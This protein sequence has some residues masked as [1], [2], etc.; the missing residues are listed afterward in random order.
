MASMEVSDARADSN[1]VVRE[2]VGWKDQDRRMLRRDVLF[3][4]LVNSSSN[5]L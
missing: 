4:Y 3:S 5:Q 2:R 1:A